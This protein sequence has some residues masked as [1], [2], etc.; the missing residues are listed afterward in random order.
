MRGQIAHYKHFLLFQMTEELR[1]EFRE[2]ITL[3][4]EQFKE[5][6]KAGR[7]QYLLSLNNLIDSIHV[8]FLQQP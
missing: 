7:D 1:N 5:T 3:R 6:F 2:E 4:F 8:R